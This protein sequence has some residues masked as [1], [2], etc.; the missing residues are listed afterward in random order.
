MQPA[1]VLERHGPNISGLTLEVADGFSAGGAALLDEWRMN[2]DQFEC[3]SSRM[4]FYALH[5]QIQ[6]E[7]RHRQQFIID[8]WKNIIIYSGA[9]WRVV[10]RATSAMTIIPLVSLREPALYLLS[11]QPS[12]YSFGSTFSH[13]SR[14]SPIGL[15]LP[16]GRVSAPAE[17]TAEPTPQL[18]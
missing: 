10:I 17:Y 2:C 11:A 7:S 1:F 15:L 12:Q 5:G 3:K 9:P 18:L 6:P 8:G 14:I 13:L 4:A 16:N